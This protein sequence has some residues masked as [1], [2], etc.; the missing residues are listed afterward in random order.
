MKRTFQLFAYKLPFRSPVHCGGEALKEREGLLLK[1]ADEDGVEGW[2]EIA[3]LPGFSVEKLEDAQRNTETVARLWCSKF[4]DAL[5]TMRAPSIRFGLEQAAMHIH[6]VRNKLPLNQLVSPH[7]RDEVRLCALLGGDSHDNMAKAI[8]SGMAGYRTVKIKVGRRAPDADAQFIHDLVDDLGADVRI[9]LDANRGW[10]LEDAVRF[11]KRVKGLSIEFIEEPVKNPL[12]L[13]AFYEQSGIPIA[14]DESSR[15]F[16]PAA[17]KKIKGVAAVV[18]K[19][20]LSGGIR[21]CIELANAA[22]NMG[23]MPVVSS[24]YESGVGT[25]GL[26]ALAAYITRPEDAAGLDAHWQLAD[27]VLGSRLDVVKGTLNLAGMKRLDVREDKLREML[28]G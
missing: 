4:P 19:P 27:D 3:P 21:S 15:E 8:R 2:G 16:K 20:T 17:W 22:V 13:P 6:T 7:G 5:A 28:R 11:G 9:R 10:S 26:A 24:S 25:L 14:L 1:L 12:A 23:A 18:L